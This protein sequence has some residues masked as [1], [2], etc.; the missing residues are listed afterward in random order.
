MG[1]APYTPDAGQFFIEVVVASHAHQ[2]RFKMTV[3]LDV[4]VINMGYEGHIASFQ[5]TQDV[6]LSMA[7]KETGATRVV[8]ASDRSGRWQVEIVCQAQAEGLLL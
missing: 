7:P 5:F 1:D 6:Q 2:V 8:Q 4:W 3:D